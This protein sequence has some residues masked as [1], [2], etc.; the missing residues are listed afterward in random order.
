MATT[1]QTVPEENL[2]STKAL[3][4]AVKLMR[5]SGSVFHQGQSNAHKKAGY[6]AAS[7]PI[8]VIDSTIFLCPQDGSIHVLKSFR[9]VKGSEPLSSSTATALPRSGYGCVLAAEI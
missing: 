2:I 1:G 7:R 6:M 3:K 4:A 8:C 5:T 9:E